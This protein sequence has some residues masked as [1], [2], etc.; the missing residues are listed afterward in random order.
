MKEKTTHRMRSEV[1]KEKPLS[2]YPIIPWKV[3]HPSPSYPDQVNLVEGHY[4]G[5]TIQG[6]PNGHGKF[7]YLH[8]K[9]DTNTFSFVYV[10][11]FLNGFLH[12]PGKKLDG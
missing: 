1:V 6:V 11:S 9:D 10:G 5:P 12:G 2:S 3:K 4:Q 7:I 8:A